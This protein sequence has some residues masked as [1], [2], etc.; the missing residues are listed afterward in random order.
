MPRKS[1]LLAHRVVQQF[2]I[3]TSPFSPHRSQLNQKSSI[4]NYQP[5]QRRI[6]KL[7]YSLLLYL[8]VQVAFAQKVE[9]KDSVTVNDRKPDS[10]KVKFYPRSFRVGTDLISIIKSQT[11]TNFSGWELN[12]DVDCGKIYLTVD[13]GNWG[14]TYDLPSPVPVPFHPLKSGSYANQGTYWRLGA[15]INLLKKDPDRN[16]FFIGLRYGHSTFNEFTTIMMIDQYF[17]SIQKQV[18]N[19]AVTAGWGELTAGLRVKIWKEFWM[20][21]TARMKFAPSVKG[22]NEVQSYDIP[23]YGQNAKGFYWGF[24]YQIFWRVPFVKQKKPTPTFPK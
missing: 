5:V 9:E 10:L 19:T 21:Y 20:G 12:G 8:L 17:G 1:L 18:T 7:S 13:I 15:D 3:P 24:N 14:R 4:V 6:L 11:Q 23:G 22:D 2:I 16:M